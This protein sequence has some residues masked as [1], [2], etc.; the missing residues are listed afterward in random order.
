MA[1]RDG[2][3]DLLA[4]FGLGNPGRSYKGTRHNVGF[5]VVDKLAEDAG[6]GVGRRRFEALIGEMMMG[7]EKLLLAKPQ[8]F[9]NESGRSVQAV[10]AWNDLGIENI[11]VVCDDLDLEPGRLRIRRKG[12]SGGHNGLK[13]IARCLGTTEFARL[14]VGIGRPRPEDAID[15]VLTTFTRAE[16]EII[17]EAIGNA[18][19][20]VR[21]WA[22]EGI[23]S[24]MNRFN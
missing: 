4:V 5:E 3:P 22:G 13:S 8:T 21:C 10:A 6:V 9:M 23:E 14:R 7:A 19:E 2:G 18:A 12:S 16:Q 15:H 20:A 1:E 24:C 17:A 11:F